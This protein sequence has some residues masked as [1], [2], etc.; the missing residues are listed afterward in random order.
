MLGLSSDTASETASPA[1]VRFEALTK[2]R[3]PGRDTGVPAGQLLLDFVDAAH[4]DDDTV[5]AKARRHVEATLGRAGMLDAAAVIG[6]FTMM[7]R[8]ADATGTPLDK[9]SI[10]MTDELRARM[11]VNDFPSA[12][13]AED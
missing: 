10:G 4:G 12:R 11:G 1:G 8:I 5:L 6:N 9:G 3:D 13:L 2:R 7:T